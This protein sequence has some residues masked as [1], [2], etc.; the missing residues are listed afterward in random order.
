MTVNRS[1]NQGRIYVDNV[2][3]TA[4]SVDSLGGI[5]GGNL[6][7]GAAKFSRITDDGLVVADT[8]NYFRG[9]IDEICFFEQALPPSLIQ[10]YS[11]RSPQGDEVGLMAYLSFSKQ[12]LSASNQMVEVAYP[13]SNVIHKDADGNI[14]YE[15]DPVTDKPTDQPLRDFIFDASITPQ[16]IIDHIDDENAAPVRPYEEL[17]NISY[18]Y[19]G[20]DNQIYFSLNEEG[21]RINKRNIYITVRDIPDKNGNAMASPA[22]AWYFVDTNPLRWIENNIFETV[23]YGNEGYMSL[24]IVNNSGIRHTYH[25]ENCPR[26]LK[27]ETSSNVIAPKSYEYLEVNVSNNLNVGTYDE[28]I[29]LV[30]ENGMAEPLYLTITVEG[31][32]P[33]WEV[34]NSLKK[35]TMNIVG[36]VN[37]NDEIDVD[38]RDIIGVFDDNN[39]CH[40]V[41]HIGNGD[42]EHLV[43]IT[44]YNNDDAKK[45]LTFRLWRYDT[46]LEMVLTT[47]PTIQFVSAA[48]VGSPENPQIFNGG[49]MY[50]QN[51]H[52]NSDWNWIS[53][54]VYGE[55]FF[56]FNKL[57]DVFNWNEGDIFTDNSTQTTL[58]YKNNH[59][60]LSGD[61]TRFRI[62]PARSYAVKVQN[63][64]DLQVGGT[65]IRQK[66]DRTITVKNGWNGIGYTP[67]MNLPV[68]TALEDYYDYA[69]EGDVIK[70]HTEF[71]VFTVSQN[72]G[73]WKG[74][75]KYMKPGEGYML[76]RNGQGIVSF[77]YPFYEP[78]ST[79]IE[80]MI[81]APA[82]TVST[83]KPY[84]M[85]LS[86]ITTGID[87]EP[88]D[89]LLAFADGEMCGAVTADTDSI[90]YMSIE[91]DKR[92]PIWFAIE[93]EGDIIA[94]TPEILTFETN[95]VVGKPN[96]PT[97]ID[98]T[99]RDIPQF[100]WY[101]LDG[102]KLSGRPTKKGV[103]I[104]NGKKY[105]ID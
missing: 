95:A 103:Y 29:Y 63:E 70:S 50:V 8:R 59:W 96:T 52:L 46:G 104:Y 41:A 44:V 74:N 34:D 39:Q 75:L 76:L 25:I 67:M 38:S 60:M 105:V 32:E 24:G 64:L 80:E 20:K 97:T 66:D 30:D 58:V 6:M 54:N 49:D 79:F 4:F 71:A 16:M 87:L 19:V 2:L 1:L 48:L 42:D 69:I 73:Y 23:W 68:S 55:N 33:Y 11:T 62:V 51:L 53:F 89:R 5:S 91:G 100:G 14:E 18:D 35:Y 21:E 45:E 65:I 7:L 57:L 28:I 47:R 22:T 92:Q 83:G 27:F 26:W 61:I 12:V 40:G 13:Y 98:F 82:S 88:G 15:K 102:L 10:S 94:T 90:F 86:A 43:Y 85:S 99:Y 84:T 72:R 78:G 101:S 31:D 37:I 77:T 17:T 9:N 3:R 36:Q 56:D 81:K 93:R